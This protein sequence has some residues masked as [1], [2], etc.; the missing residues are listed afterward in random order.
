V[1]NH[2]SLNW[3]PIRN[4][5]VKR[6]DTGTRSKLF[7]ILRQN[8]EHVRHQKLD[9]PYVHI[10]GVKSCSSD[11]NMAKYFHEQ[12]DTQTTTKYALP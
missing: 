3:F 5:K 2:L 10:V 12:T 9:L 1:I 11:V 7:E 6:H 4:R 8:S